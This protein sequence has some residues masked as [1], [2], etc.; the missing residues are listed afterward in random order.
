LGHELSLASG[1]LVAR[2]A[3][4]EADARAAAD[5]LGEVL[6]QDETT[7]SV[8]E[9]SDQRWTVEVCFAGAIDEQP[10][11]RLIANALG[12]EVAQALTILRVAA[13][14][15][16]AESLDGLKPVTAGR[17]VIHGSHDR[18]RIPPNALAIEIDAALAFGTGHHGT[19]R[20]CLLALAHVLKQRHAGRS[21]QALRILDIGTGTGVLAIAAAK[22]LRR[23]VVASEIDPQ[24]ARVASHNVRRNGVAS[25]VDTIVARGLTHPR[26]THGAPYELIFANI[27]LGPLQRLAAPISA[28]A[29]SR[30]V[31]ILSGL[32]PAHANA[33]LAS[34]R[35]ASFRLTRR[36]DLDGWTTLVMRPAGRR[37]RRSTEGSPH[38]WKRS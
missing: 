34:Y 29:S 5:V 1:T 18:A 7:V 15:W 33:A 17:F 37:L 3:L 38:E 13:R 16:V 28:V 24:A 6:D 30:T 25:L 31:L 2:I 26:V 32:L 4:A 11:R 36:I 19:T 10:A 35:S 8:F 20:G 27:L 12:R 23:H 22:A 21:R 9:V 14:D